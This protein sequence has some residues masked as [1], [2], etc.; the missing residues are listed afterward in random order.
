M[1]EPRANYLVPGRKRKVKCQLTVENVE[2]CAE[3]VKHGTKCTLHPPDTEPSSSNSPVSVDKQ[4]NE[5]RLERIESLL[6]LLVEA[7]EQPR[8]AEGSLEPDA[9][10]PASFWNNF[11]IPAEYSSLQSILLMSYQFLSSTDG[12]LP[13]QAG[14]GFDIPQP[15]YTPDAKQS[16]VELLPSAQDAASIIA[17]TTAWLWGAETPAGSVLNPD[18]TTQLLDITAVAKG[19][20]MHIAKT[21]LLFALYMQQLPTSLDVQ[22]LQS[23]SVE[24]TI[25]SIMERVNLF[26]SS[27]EREA[28]S[29]DGL[30]CLILLSLIQLNDGAIRKAWITFRRVLDI[31]RLQGLHNSF[32]LNARNSTDSNMALRRRLW[33]STVCGDCYCSIL[34]GL[35]PGLGIAPF[36]PNDETWNDPLADDDANVQRRICLL[37]ARI[38]QRNAVGL[39]RDRSILRE[40]DEALDKLQDSMPTSWWK[41]PSF[42]QDRSLDS[43]KEPNRLI[44]Q[45]WFFHARMFVHLP[46]A[47]GT[48]TAALSK[49][50]E[51]CIEASRIT[52]QRYLG[53][54]PARAQLSRCRSVDQIAFIAAV[55]LLLAKVQIRHHSV[56]STA[57]RYDLDRALL[58]QVTDSFEAV[59]KASRSERIAR[60]CSGIL[61]TML[62]LADADLDAASFSASSSSTDPN[63]SSAFGV[64]S[65][66]ETSAEDTSGVSKSEMEDIIA[67]SIQP[68]LESQGPA[69]HLVT[70]LFAM[71]RPTRE[72]SK[73]IQEPPSTYDAFDLDDLVDSSALQQPFIADLS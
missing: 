4:G 11:V 41:A 44:C 34:L 39:Y 28:C 43:A 46:F 15:T 17:N 72:T 20:A 32:S 23:Q 61:S 14:Q 67:S 13:Y 12:S 31:A 16:L 30:E 2:T 56:H 36:G 29:L 54:Q 9:A 70:L 68:V 37:V 33:L 49:S 6:K 64:H 18:D 19:N 59:G 73:L 47:F 10:V 60:Q 38:A 52:L 26:V 21:L 40:I 45:L 63:T 5:T 27:H 62:S 1:P 69:A 66:A 25:E 24:R 3:C 51:N 8:L 53:L 42:S 48:T 50:L 55:I 57:S 35:E 58:E 22:W 7:Q 65:N 71:K